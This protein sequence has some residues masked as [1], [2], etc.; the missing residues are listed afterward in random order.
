VSEELPANA[1]LPTSVPAVLKV[2]EVL[3]AMSPETFGF[4]SQYWSIGFQLAV[5]SFTW[6]RYCTST[7]NSPIAKL[8]VIPAL[9]FSVA[10]SAPLNSK[11][12]APLEAVPMPKWVMALL[13]PVAAGNVTAAAL[14]A[15]FPETVQAEP[16]RA[17]ATRA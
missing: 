2:S 10:D 5:I 14:L 1:P 11:F 4:V 8:G 13:P 7:S 12:P 17:I 3:P 16:L 9:T 6:Q 15:L